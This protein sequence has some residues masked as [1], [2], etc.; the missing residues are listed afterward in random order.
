M[1]YFLEIA[2][3]GT[4]YAGW[5]IQKNAFAVQQELNE[6][7]E[8]VFRRP[9]ATVGSGRTDTGVHAS[10]QVVHIDM[11]EEFTAK[12]QHSLN[13][14]LSG[15]IAING[16]RNVNDD[17]H[18][19]F[20]AI[21]RAYEYKIICRKDPFSK[22]FAMVYE[23]NLNLI[24]MNKACKILLQHKDF[25]SFSKV[26][27]EVNHFF[28]DIYRAEWVV[29]GNFTIFYIEANRFLRGMV[30]AIGGTL[31]EIGKGRLLLEDFEKI[32]LAK[33]RKQASSA[34][35]AHGLTLTKVEYPEGIFLD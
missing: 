5:Q 33:D 25:E 21:R 18:A 34:L 29:E 3:K 12:H 11:E 8:K 16:F 32:I 30:R 1:R 24:E 22:D 19:R 2:Y 4:A 17:A 15:D 28:C 9:I 13:C 27:T 6:A 26:H 20:D 7:L 14:I 35:P 23:R 31:L 10:Q